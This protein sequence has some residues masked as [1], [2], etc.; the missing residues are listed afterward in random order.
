MSDA[1]VSVAPTALYVYGV[2]SGDTELELSCAGVGSG[3]VRVLREGDLA[4]VVGDVTLDEFDQ[5]PLRTN[6]ENPDWLAET[7]RAHEGVLERALGT[8]TVI[9]F[10]IASLY[11]DEDNLREFLRANR[12]SLLESLTRL[13]GKVELGVKAFF[14]RTAAV[15]RDAAGAESGSDYLRRR[16]EEQ[17]AGR[18]ADAF[19]IDCARTSHAHLAEAALDARSNRPQ[20][21]ELSGR[22]ERMLLNGAY[23]VER[24]DT[25]LEAALRELEQG[26]GTQGVTYELTGPWPPYNFVPQELVGA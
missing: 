19:V 10:R 6:L 12:D 11:G 13:D 4:A 5:E 15:S 26:F 9:P 16:Q 17:L 24:G 14:D 7:A 25:Q 1:T 23:L 8:T 2:V 18:D 21:P 22:A 20:A 3:D